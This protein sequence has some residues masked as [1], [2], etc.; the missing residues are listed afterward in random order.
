MERTVGQA[1]AT[2]VCDKTTLAGRYKVQFWLK[3]YGCGRDAA[4][5][6][7]DLETCAVRSRSAPITVSCRKALTIVVRQSLNRLSP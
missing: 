7:R 3:G 1:L 4:V 2:A 6:G 5:L